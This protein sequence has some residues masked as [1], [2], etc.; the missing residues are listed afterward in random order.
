MSTRLIEPCCAD[1]QVPTAIREK[2]AALTATSGDVTMHHWMRAASYMAGPQWELTVQT[3]ELTIAHLRYIREWMQRGWASHVSLTIAQ[4]QRELILSELS[5]LGERVS[6]AIDGDMKDECIAFSG[7]RGNVVII[8][9]V[10]AE[11]QPGLSLY[12]ISHTK[13][14]DPDEVYQAICSRHKLRK[15]DAAFPLSRGN[16]K[17]SDQ[18]TPAPPIQEGKAP[19]RVRRKKGTS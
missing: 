6:I 15:V 2:T 11:T 13:P 17:G 18:T 16:T 12:A 7:E 19:K 10:I 14:G 3:A 8:G 5:G 4:D 1:R 9:R